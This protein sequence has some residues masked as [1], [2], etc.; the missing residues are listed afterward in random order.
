MLLQP[1]GFGKS[2]RI[3]GYQK[4]PV[5]QALPELSSAKNTTFV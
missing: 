1:P 3:G 5:M 2:F 4:L